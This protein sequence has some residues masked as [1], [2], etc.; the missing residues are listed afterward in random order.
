MLGGGRVD[1][2]A[3]CFEDAAHL[4]CLLL[5]ALREFCRGIGGV[6]VGAALEMREKLFNVAGSSSAEHGFDGLVRRDVAQERCI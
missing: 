4:F 1:V 2:F 6:L 3:L 5:A